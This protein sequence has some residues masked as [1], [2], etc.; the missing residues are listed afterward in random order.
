MRTVRDATE[1][2]E[3]RDAYQ[4][5]AK[6]HLPPYTEALR[7]YVEQRGVGWLNFAAEEALLEEHFTRGDHFNEAGAKV[8]TKL[9]AERLKPHLTTLR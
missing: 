6:R 2:K 4:R 3:G 1:E 8:F 9:F 7:Q 5:S